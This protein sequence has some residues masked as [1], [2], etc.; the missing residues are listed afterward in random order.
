MSH[1][2]EH[3]SDERRCPNDVSAPLDAADDLVR[4]SFG[5]RREGLR[6]KAG[7]HPSMDKPGA[8][9]HDLGA[10]TYKRVTESLRECVKPRFR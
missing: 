10:G 8:N 3:P 9:N 5:R 1:D 7:C 2:E 4:Y 6:S